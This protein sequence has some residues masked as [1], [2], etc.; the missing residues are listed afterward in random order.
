MWGHK[1]SMK[2]LAQIN[3]ENVYHYHHSRQ[4][5]KGFCRALMTMLFLSLVTPVFFFSTYQRNLQPADY[6]RALI[7]EHRPL[8]V[9]NGGRGT[10][11]W[12]VD[13][14]WNDGGEQPQVQHV[15]EK[16][17]VERRLTTDTEGVNQVQDGEGVH[18]E[19]VRRENL[20]DEKGVN[21]GGPEDSIERRELARQEDELPQ[22]QHAEEKEKVQGRATADTEEGNQDLDGD[23]VHNGP[24]QRETPADE[25]EVDDAG[26]DDT[27]E[28]R[29]SE[30]QDEQVAKTAED[31]VATTVP[32][33]GE[34]Q[35]EAAKTTAGGLGAAGPPAVIVQVT[36]A[37]AGTSTKD[38]VDDYRAG[39]ISRIQVQI[40]LADELMG[41]ARERENL[42]LREHLESIK[43]RCVQAVQKLRDGS[44]DIES[45]NNVVRVAE[46]ATLRAKELRSSTIIMEKL[47]M[48]LQESKAKLRNLTKE[49]NILDLVATKSLPKG[50]HCLSMQLTIG[51]YN[52]KDSHT[53]D[54]SPEVLEDNSRFHYALFSDNVLAASV[55]VKSLRDNAK[56]PSRHVIHLVTD[57]MNKPAMRAWFRRHS[58]YPAV[59]DIKTV[60][61]FSDWLTPEHCPV[62]RFLQESK[63]LQEFYNNVDGP[64]TKAGSGGDE[65]GIKH[66]NPKYL[67]MLNHLR[68]YLPEVYPK[69]KKVVF[70]DDDIVVQKDLAPLWDV[71]LEG[72]VNGAVFTCRGKFH[73]LG[74]YLNFSHPDIKREF[75]EDSCGWAYGM[76]VF[77]LDR[78]REQNLTEVYH[79]WQIANEGRLLWKL[80]TLPPGL[81]TF[82]NRT[83]PL[84]KS[85]H[86]LGL[87][88]D[89]EVTPELAESAAVVHYNGNNKP[90]LD[91]AISL[92][93][94]YWTRY[95]ETKDPLI[96]ECNINVGQKL[97]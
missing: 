96:N 15:V 73:R 58:P 29:E 97:K 81:L 42:P 68:F 24:V 90:W 13:D 40:P 7:E 50:L 32:P 53:I 30:E 88:Y 33:G 37:A 6:P 28:R 2:K 94:K 80:G 85:W 57:A 76:N 64:A 75:D 8:R 3:I 4:L 93:R 95:V 60:E 26:T 59:M 87:G 74:H 12:P 5:G 18:I 77:D 71:D 44:M 38:P 46:L 52:D 49:R 47:R 54:P 84:D 9:L 55:V 34:T 70:L 17:E 43:E 31:R 11:G 21:G 65:K 78:W 92:Y 51:Y 89:P 63:A 69:L 23:D 61:D 20:P 67:S 72:N 48:E 10:L 27:P 16:E 39:L 19:P 36:A 41:F 66:R 62:L 14:T 35:A 91:I 25:K 83:H 79:K 22:M 1:W 86:Q 56:D 45:G 82:Y